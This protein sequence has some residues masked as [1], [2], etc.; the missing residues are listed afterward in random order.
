MR[1][2][3]FTG[4]SVREAMSAVRREI[5]RD[6]VILSTRTDPANGQ[7]SVVAAV[8]DAPSP[9]GDP[10]HQAP[11]SVAAPAGEPG[12]L[13]RLLDFHRV[14]ERIARRVA[15]LAAESAGDN[16]EDRLAVSLDILFGFATLP[17]AARRPLMLVGPPGAGKTTTAAKLAA[18]S[19]L[20]GKPVRLVTT[21]TVRSGALAQLGDLARLIGA[22]CRQVTAP[23]DLVRHHAE[24][25][26]QPMIIDTAGASP[27][28]VED[29]Q[30][31]RRLARAIDAEL[32]LVLPAGLDPDDC[33]DMARAF[34]AI[35]TRLLI[36]TRL[37]T[38]RRYGGLLSAAE[39]ADLDLTEVSA[40]ASLTD[41]LRPLNPCSLARLLSAHGSSSAPQQRAAS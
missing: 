6:A 23:E 31:L 16:D 29:L 28:D 27:F 30:R 41:A 3:T 12:E 24:A 34:A 4:A 13:D 8:D 7:C 2:R 36:A 5:G 33:A 19:A 11:A 1:L 32:A 9:A 10:Q 35:G 37:D 20:E 40:A 15:R 22:P 26:E 38:A 25:P 21:D 39:A 18:R 17:L 14:P